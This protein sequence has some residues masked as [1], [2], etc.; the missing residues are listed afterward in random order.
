MD[1]MLAGKIAL[2]AGG[3][4]GCGL[5][6]SQELAREGIKVVLT[7]RQADIVEAAVKSIRDAGGQAEGF[8]G[9]MDSEE[10]AR[11][12]VR[13]T[14]DTFGEPG[15]L[16]FNPPSPRLADGWDNIELADYDDSHRKFTM[17][18]VYLLREM[19]PHMKASRWGRVINVS[20]IVKTPHLHSPMYHHNTRVASVSITKTLSF[21]MARF[22]ITAN[23]IAPGAFRSALS[24]EYLGR[25]GQTEEVIETGTPMAR[26]GLPEEMAGLVA[27]LCSDRASFISGET[28]RVDGGASLSL[29]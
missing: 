24:A 5:A 11:A 17:A 12:M 16:V 21:E 23:S 29:F 2:V 22:G 6:I 4:R 20:S 19:V 10:G 14:R 25:L 27:F 3:A 9:E 7:G 18:L 8:I 15:I 28:I 26:M 13:R 1:L